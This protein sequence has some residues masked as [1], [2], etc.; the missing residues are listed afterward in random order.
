V[1]EHFTKHVSD[2]HAYNNTLKT[3]GK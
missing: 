2:V 1:S 3:Q